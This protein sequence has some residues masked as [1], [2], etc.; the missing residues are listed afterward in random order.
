[1]SQDVPINLL[2]DK[3][4]DLCSFKAVRKVHEIDRHKR[5]EQ[6]IAADRSAG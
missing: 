2:E 1:M 4:G 6:M 3:E 5:K